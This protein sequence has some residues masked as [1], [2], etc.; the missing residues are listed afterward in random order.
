MRG[1]RSAMCSMFALGFLGAVAALLFMDSTTHAQENTHIWVEGQETVSEDVSHHG[2]YNSV[3]RDQLSEGGWISHYDS[4]SAGEVVYEVDIP[5]DGEYSFWL[6]ANPSG[7]E[8]QYRVDGGEWEPVDMSDPIDQVNIADGGAL[9]HRFIAWLDMGTLELD[10]GSHRIAF[11]F[12][13]G[14]S[15]SG[16]I[17][18]FLLT[19][20]QAFVPRGSAKPGERAGEAA[21]GFFAWEP[22]AW[23]PEM[24]SPFDLRYLNEETAGESGFVR[25]E[26][27]GFVLGDGA[28]VRF[29]TVQGDGLQGIARNRQEWWAERLAAYGVNLVRSGGTAFFEEWMQGDREAFEERLDN[30]HAMV[31]ALKDAGVYVYI[32]HLFWHTHT[33]VTLPPEVFPG[34]EDGETALA[35]LFFSDDFQDYYLEFMEELMTTPNPYTGLPMAEDPAVAFLEI[36]NESNLLFHT[37]DPDN[38]V[39]TE[40]ELVERSFGDWLVEKYGSLE[41]ARDAWGDE[42]HP[43]IHTPDD[44][45][46]G[47]VGLYGAGHLTGA[48]WARS[49]R[50]GPRASDQLRFMV[51]AQK[52]LYER[53]S[54][55]LREDAGVNQAIA[56]GNW[57]TADERILGAL[58][59]YTY[60]GADLVAHNSYFSTP[61]EHNPR[62]YRVEVGDQYR[63]RS[64]LTMPEGVGSLQR[65]TYAGFPYMITENNWNRP[66]RFRAEFPVLV[67]A[68]ASLAGIDG[69][70]F[71]AHDTD[72]WDSA[73][74]VWGINDT[75]VLGQFPA[76]ALLYR[77]GDVQTGETVVHEALELEDLYAFEG[78]AIQADDGIEDPLYDD[79][80]RNV[81]EGESAPSRIDPLAFYVGGVTRRAGAGEADENLLADLRPYIDRENETVRSTTDELRWDYGAGLMTINTPRAQGATGFLSEAGR[82]ELDD[83]VIESG[84]EYGSIMVISLDGEPLSD[85]E[86]ILVQASTEDRPSGFNTE[87]DNG[88][89][90]IADL[91]GYPL[92]VRLIDAAVTIKRAG[93]SEAAVLDGNGY[94]TEREADAE[95]GE[96]FRVRLPEDELYT[97]VK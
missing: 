56:P 3:N 21:P 33:T 28:P 36:Q 49:Q 76:T 41:A 54:R 23:D 35:L 22:D 93:L 38:L 55:M 5:A 57:K 52:R 15:N 12:D 65:Q 83:I 89:H 1:T 73:M 68:Y 63:N 71:F 88:L 34:F 82:I 27:D 48:D 64:A 86:S 29:W 94:V 85:S 25:R 43:G 17:D 74:K 16:G 77:R 4:E 81:E 46:A 32:N 70:L 61:H 59:H 62:F 39:E 14:V 42:S 75:T 30:Y 18:C 66:N 19:L 67:S 58:E 24:E 92:N 26:G 31:A 40:R 7:S 72:P 13:G 50:N 80:L 9:D 79:L 97:L 44:F 6:R 45:D 37:F 11:R 8:M 84:N 96:A 87:E 91:G 51:E 95:A 10:D 20:D 69:W 2:W 60:T 90:T 53:M 78:Q 47:R